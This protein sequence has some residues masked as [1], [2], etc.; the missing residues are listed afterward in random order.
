[1]YDN[2]PEQINDIRMEPNYS[3]AKDTFNKHFGIVILMNK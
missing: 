3:S 2:K 1:M